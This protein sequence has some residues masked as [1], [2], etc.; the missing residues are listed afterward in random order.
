[1]AILYIANANKTK[2]K[3]RRGEMSTRGRGGRGEISRGGGMIVIGSR[4]V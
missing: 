2:T 3:L 4:G 1:M